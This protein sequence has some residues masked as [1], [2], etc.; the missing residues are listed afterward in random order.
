MNKCQCKCGKLVKNKWALGHNR[1]GTTFKHTADAK[2]KC[3]LTKIG[4]LNPRFGKVGTCLG[5]K[6]TPEQLKKIRDT[7]AKQIITPEHRKNISLGM[8]LAN[9]EGRR[10]NYKGGE[11]TRLARAVISVQK[12]RI[13]KKNNGGSFSLEEWEELKERFNFMCLCCKRAEPEIKLAADHIIPLSK[14]GGSE[15][16]NIQPLCKSCNSR[17]MTKTIDYISNYY[18]PIMV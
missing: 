8:M 12:R 1:K 6:Q 16:Q 15:I 7:R 4:E 14:G 17:K 3:R 13:L 18:E 10:S 9:K 5:R 2:N 11:A